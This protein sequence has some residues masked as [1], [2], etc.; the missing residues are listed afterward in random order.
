MECEALVGGCVPGARAAGAERA[1]VFNAEKLAAYRLMEISRSI[2]R[3]VFGGSESEVLLWAREMGVW[4]SS[5]HAYTY[6]LLRRE[7]GGGVGGGVGGVSET[8]G[9]VARRDEFEAAAAMLFQMMCFGWGVL[10]FGVLAEAERRWVWIDHDGV[11][12]AWSG[13]LGESAAFVSDVDRRS[14]E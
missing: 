1:V 13:R 10:V 9:H 6:Q 14:G 2:V 4:E 3:W 8:P 12:F 11:L 5:E 7:A